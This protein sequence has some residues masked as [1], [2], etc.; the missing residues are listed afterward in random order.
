MH[1]TEVVPFQILGE[2]IYVN[3][4]N[5]IVSLDRVKAEKAFLRI[6]KLPGLRDMPRRRMNLCLSPTE[7]CNLR[8][9]YCFNKSHLKERLSPEEAVSLAG[10]GISLFP[11]F[12]Q[13]WIDLSGKGEPILNLETVLALASWAKEKQEELRREILVTFVTNGTLLSP[14]IV[15]L[16]QENEIIFGISI[17]GTKKIHDSARRT[18]GGSPTFDRIIRN[19]RAIEDKSFLGAAMTFGG[20]PFPLAEAMDSLLPYFSTIALKPV[21]DKD[22]FTRENMENWFEEYDHLVKTL[23]KRAKSGDRRLLFA[24]LNGDDYFGKFLARSYQG[25]LSILRCDAGLGRAYITK[26]GKVYPCAPLS[27]YPECSIGTA[28]GIAKGSQEKLFQ[29]GLGRHECGLCPF[30]FACGGECLANILGNKGRVD[31]LM[32]ALKKHL[33]L[34]AHWL[35]SRLEEECPEVSSQVRSFIDER[36]RLIGM[37]KEYKEIVSSHPELSFRECKELYYRS[38]SREKNYLG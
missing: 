16:L 24:L 15:H 5:G 25:G 8:C 20:S 22:A 3:S 35:H 33:I 29:E 4:N 21:R 13:Y 6:G 17:D 27:E 36:A 9:R 37:S 1:P 26:E 38:R 32:C 18:A 19:V 34:L 10:K 2:A 31:P 14:D 30:R 28:E 11:G 23:L 7:E 12:E